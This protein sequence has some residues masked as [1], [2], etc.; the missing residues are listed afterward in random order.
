[1]PPSHHERL[2]TNY[3]EVGVAVMQALYS[4]DYLSIG[5]IRS[6]DEL[7][8]VAGVSQNKLV[9][10]VGCGV[11][12][13]MLHLAGTRGCKVVGID[14]LESNI[15]QCRA[16]STERGLDH[17]AA[18]Q[19][20]DATSLPFDDATF[21]VV[22]GQDAWCHV[23]DKRAM[24]A[25]ARRVLRH[26]GTIAFTDWLVGA[27]MTDNERATALDAALSATAVTASEYLALLAEAGFDEVAYT[28]IS[29]TFVAQYQQVCGRLDTNKAQLCDRFGERV[30][31][32]VS[33]INGTILKGFQG[34]AITGGRFTGRA[35]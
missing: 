12:G 4:D 16:R 22:W 10:D 34:S 11:G 13:P 29:S 15:V 23:P 6:T 3:N 25:E 27:G 18:F 35:V 19:E 8:D 14:L 32:I 7:A 17:L 26:G 33:D 24:L 31:D 2:Q 1:M 9:L 28:D 30:Y 5:G 21:D 20:A